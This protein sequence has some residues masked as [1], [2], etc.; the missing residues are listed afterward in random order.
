[1]IRLLL[2]SGSVSA[3]SANRAVLD[4]VERAASV[5]AEQV[6]VAWS[7]PV[8]AL[9]SFQPD[10]VDDPPPVVA[11][12]REQLEAA[13]AIVIAAPEYAGGVAGSMKNALDWCVGSGSIYRRPVAVA[14]A[15]TTG[16][17]HAQA[18]LVRT[19]L[20]QGA[21][22]VSSLG[23]AAPKTKSDEHGRIVDHATLVEI[24]SLVSTLLA[25]VD[26][27]PVERVVEVREIARRFGIDPAQV[28]DA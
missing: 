27:A 14:S 17:Q 28:H 9:P 11:S 23:I 16:G 13:D 5:R 22:V 24:E 18:Q 25:A 8:G 19:L 10:L 3:S 4:V 20:W 1:V 26:A 15:G 2:V 21:H 7:G 6:A 12:F